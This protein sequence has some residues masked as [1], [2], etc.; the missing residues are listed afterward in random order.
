MSKKSRLR[1]YNDISKRTLS[2]DDMNN[3]N[4]SY[5]YEDNDGKTTATVTFVTNV[6]QKDIEMTVNGK[7]PNSIWLYKENDVLDITCKVPEN[8]NL[9]HDARIVEKT[10][11]ENEIVYENEKEIAS[12]RFTL[13][14]KHNNGSISCI[15]VDH[16]KKDVKKRIDMK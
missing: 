7:S 6:K 8:K 4:L 13:D 9:P 16:D 12:H 3:S 2:V 15:K 14:N 11:G 1:L 5:E 10:T